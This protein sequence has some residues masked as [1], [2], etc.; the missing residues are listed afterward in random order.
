MYISSWINSSMDLVYLI[1]GRRALLSSVLFY[2]DWFDPR[3][4]AKSIDASVRLLFDWRS[5]NMSLDTK[6]VTYQ[7]LYSICSVKLMYVLYKLYT[8]TNTQ[9]HT[10][11]YS[12]PQ[13]PLVSNY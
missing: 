13:G 10:H 11:T 3:F 5:N 7:H 2:Q 1:F 12:N 4:Y 9:T 8:H 6:A